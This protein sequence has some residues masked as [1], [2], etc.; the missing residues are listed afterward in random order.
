MAWIQGIR[1]V[2]IDVDGTLLDGDRAIAGAAQALDRLRGRALARRRILESGRTHAVLLVPPAARVDFEGVVEDGARPDWVVVG[3]LGRGFTWER[4]NQAF[5]WIRGGATLLA[6]HKNRSWDNGMDG[7]VL[8]AGPFV[9]ALEYATGAT[10]E[11][12]GKPARAF[13]DLALADLGVPA[14]EALVVGDDLE[15]DCEGGAA[16]NEDDPESSGSENRMEPTQ[17][18]VRF[19][20]DVP[21]AGAPWERDAR[22]HQVAPR[23]GDGYGERQGS[24]PVPRDPASVPDGRARAEWAVVGGGLLNEARDMVDC[25]RARARCRD[26][27]RRQHSPRGSDQRDTVDHRARLDFTAA[28]WSGVEI[29][30]PGQAGKLET[31]HH[32]SRVGGRRAA[33]PQ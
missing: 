32:R 2:L 19:T 29:G 17:D 13:F 6:L 1:G 4:L 3:D 5:H 7:V 16:A 10:A 24:A 8:D 31:D 15:A 18:W 14:R 12:V 33:A 28:A 27:S 26:L 20:L 30:G 21:M 11:L 22:P 23:S 25:G 9:A